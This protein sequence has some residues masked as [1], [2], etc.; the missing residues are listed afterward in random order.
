MTAVDDYLRDIPAGHRAATDTIA[1]KLS[2]WTADL[3]AELQQVVFRHN[4]ANHP[5]F[6]DAA[7]VFEDA[8]EQLLLADAPRTHEVPL[9]FVGYH[10]MNRFTR[11][12]QT[13]GFLVTDQRL[14]VQENF[15]GVFGRELPN[16]RMLPLTSADPVAASHALTASVASAYDWSD[17]VKLFGTE[18]AEGHSPE[19]RLT[20]LLTDAVTSVVQLSQALG[21]AV[22]GAPGADE[23]EEKS[24][25]AELVPRL[26][27]LGIRSEV[28]LADDPRLAKML[29]KFGP[30]VGLGGD[31]TIAF[32]SLDK[33]FAGVY[34]I[35]VTDIAVRSCD[36]MEEP[37]VSLRSAIDPAAIKLDEQAKAIITEPGVAH[38][39]VSHLSA[40]VKGG[41]VTAM[42]ELIAGDV[43]P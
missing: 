43:T 24:T 12:R 27:E 26:A 21:L 42:R 10:A 28:M 18:S 37:I 32:A 31:E 38:V 11:K 40:D 4:H 3:D 41:I 7:Q 23:E 30:K 36:L 1:A 33:T 2:L 5:V 14:I 35:V 8:V 19:F 22:A 29:K 34:G 25:A 6:D 16:Y 15:G 20:Q 17:L 9:L 13:M 39:L